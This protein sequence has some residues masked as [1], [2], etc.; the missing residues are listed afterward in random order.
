VATASFYYRDPSAPIPNQPLRVVVV[1]FVEYGG[2]VL[3]ERRSDCGQWCLIG[4]RIEDDQSV[5]DA[6]R[7]EVHEE[8]G[9]AVASFGLFGMFSDPSMIARYEL[10]AQSLIARVMSLAFTV[11]VDNVS[12]LA[13]SEESLELR[14]F[15]RDELRTLDIIPTVRHIV[16]R[17]LEAPATPV[18]E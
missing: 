16:D 14:F 9:L 7:A 6:L 13:C 12:T 1:A 10:P 15:S 3:M 8:T 2:R 18:L 5:E 11:Q 17:Y 4:G